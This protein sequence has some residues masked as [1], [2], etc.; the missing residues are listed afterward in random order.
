MNALAPR[1]LLRGLLGG[2]VIAAALPALAA[3]K[4]ECNPANTPQTIEG[5]V[6]RAGN[7][8]VVVKQPDGNVHEF[9]ADDKTAQSYKPGDKIKAKLRANPKC[10]NK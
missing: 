6:I 2:L 9:Q 1:N 8:R 3:E 5:T 4:P 10:E 7:G